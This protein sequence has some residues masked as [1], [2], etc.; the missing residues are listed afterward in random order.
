MSS[1]EDED[2]IVA[3][4]DDISV[5]EPDYPLHNQHLLS[6]LLY[7]N[8][9]EDLPNSAHSSKPFHKPV[10]N[11]HQNDIGLSNRNV[12][13]LA[14]KQNLPSHIS[15]DS[16][17]P[18]QE[19]TASKLTSK[20]ATK[21][22]LSAGSSLTAF[23]SYLGSGERSLEG[24]IVRSLGLEKLT[25]L[26]RVSRARV[27]VESLEVEPG[28]VHKVLKERGSKGTGKKSLIPLSQSSSS[29]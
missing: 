24:S 15:P 22:P 23:S 27:A 14:A 12:E 4:L 19:V 17:A 11:E 20:L 28:L 16:E 10:E 21:D 3:G 8:D 25:N 7:E 29:W 2:D 18:T 9:N 1:E 6:R 13:C 5:V 26:G